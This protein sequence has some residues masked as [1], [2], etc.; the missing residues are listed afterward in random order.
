MAFFTVATVPADAETMVHWNDISIRIPQS[1]SFEIRG[2]MREADRLKKKVV[3]CALYNLR[4]KCFKERKLKAGEEY[5]ANLTFVRPVALVP[6]SEDVDGVISY[7]KF[8]T[9]QPPDEFTDKVISGLEE[10]R[11]VPPDEDYLRNIPNSF[12]PLSALDYQDVGYSLASSTVGGTSMLE[13]WRSLVGKLPSRECV[14][15]D[16]PCSVTLKASDDGREALALYA[17]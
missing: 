9:S 13:Q 16:Q 1:F 2:P 4:T 11:Y 15:D 6:T 17:V 10:F 14:A 5:G 12:T 3:D 7:S 8:Y